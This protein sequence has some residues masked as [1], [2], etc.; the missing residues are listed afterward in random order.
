MT[1]TAKEI[2]L[3]MLEI[4]H[5][6][7]SAHIGSNL[8]CIDILTAI[9]FKCLNLPNSSDKNFAK[10]D[11]FMLSKAH[12]A[13]ALYCT[14]Y[15]KGLLSEVDLNSFYTNDGKLPAHL[16]RF[17][18]PYIE[19]SAGSLGHGLAM[20]VGFA[21]GI[22]NEL[23]LQNRRRA[24]FCLMGDGESQEGS[25]WE[26]AMIA[27]RLNLNN[28]IVLIDYNNLQGYGRA[29]E[30]VA[31][32]PLREKWLA[33]GFECVE[34]DG[35]DEDAISSVILSYLN[36]PQNKPLCV[37]CKTIKGKGVSFM[38]DNLV[39]HYYAISDDEFK[40]AKKELK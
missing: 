16:D 17:S 30:L 32:E 35:H 37:I 24:V 3:K 36:T 33:F 11:I 27:P 13:L 26:A 9:Y 15:K 14:L 12:S 29:K 8:S 25:I 7:K 21:L 5:R 10:R 31:F 20:A 18:N 1:K 23:N 34:L 39:W 6:V 38:E 2:R 40:Q 4:S 22:K 19:I 28:L